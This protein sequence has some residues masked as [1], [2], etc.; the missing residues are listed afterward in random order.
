MWEDYFSVQIFFIILRETLESAII[1]SVLLS[2]VNQNFTSIDQ[3]GDTYLTVDPKQIRQYKAQIWIGALSGL[4]IC[5]GIGGVFIAIFYVIGN[6]IWSAAERIWEGVFSILSALIISV[7]GL[8]LLRINSMQTKWKSKLGKSLN[9]NNHDDD[10]HL[11]QEIEG[12]PLAQDITKLVYYKR[13]MDEFGK[14]YALGILP[15]V[16]TLREGL[17][18]VVFVGGIGVNQ[19]ASSFPLAIF[20]GGLVGGIVGVVMY[21]GGNKMS[22]QYFLILSSCFLYMV[23]AGLVSRGV[24][25]LELEQF[26]QKCGQD[27]SETGSGPG[28]YDISNT[29]W[30]VNCCNGLTDGGWMLLNALVGWTNT[31][32]YVQRKIRSFAICPIKI[33]IEGNQEENCFPKNFN[34]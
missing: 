16:T 19:P 14:K 13:K 20:C 11:L 12:E 1:I 7:M 2:F 15:F 34:S 18:A 33:P 21:R 8:A 30:H 32:T 10:E 6:D 28:S 23:A 29:I 31:A 22:L 25:F 26:V 17:E 9:D 27:T 24:W 5:L 3:N 4:A